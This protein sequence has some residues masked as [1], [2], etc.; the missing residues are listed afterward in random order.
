VSDAGEFVDAA[1]QREGTWARAE[2]EQARL[3]SDLVF[4]GCSVGAIRGAIRDVARR[5]PTP[6]HD[7][8]TALS[9]ELWSAPVFERRLAAVVLLQSKL[10]ILRNSDL[11]RLEGFVRTARLRALLDPLAVDVV[12][13]M[14]DSMD[15]SSG[16]YLATALDRWSADDDVW[17][18]RACVMAPLRALRAGTGEWRSFVL[19]ARTVGELGT[20]NDV[21]HEAIALVR[22]DVAKTHPELRL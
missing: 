13:P 22:A 11:T 8:I 20:G 17:V 19:R 6:S 4:Y 16:A 1:L 5:Y 21:A 12:G 3:A 9:S 7:E 14:M 2:R 15:A 10:E 18:R